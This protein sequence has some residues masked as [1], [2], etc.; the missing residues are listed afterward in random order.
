MRCVYPSSTDIALFP[1]EGCRGCD[2]NDMTI[3]AALS[4]HEVPKE[5]LDG[6]YKL[7][8]SKENV[9]IDAGTKIIEHAKVMHFANKIDG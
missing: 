7:S 1:G 6:F 8:D 3:V 9:R 5:V 4:A 2:D